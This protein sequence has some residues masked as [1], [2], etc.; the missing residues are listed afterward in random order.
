[1]TKGLSGAHLSKRATAFLGDLSLA[2]NAF[3]GFN[4]KLVAF[5]QLIL[6]E[7]GDFTQSWSRIS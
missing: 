7:G 1:M 3:A 5:L 4:D 6:S 2:W